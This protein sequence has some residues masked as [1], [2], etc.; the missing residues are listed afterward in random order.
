ME[1]VA[2]FHHRS[3]P[4]QSVRNNS[5]KLISG[6]GGLLFYIS[7]IRLDACSVDS[8]FRHVFFLRF[9]CLESQ[10][11]AYQVSSDLSIPSISGRPG[12]EATR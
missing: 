11:D 10:Q 12:F 3:N 7:F 9:T 5:E 6:E 1:T 4:S 8:R 2:L